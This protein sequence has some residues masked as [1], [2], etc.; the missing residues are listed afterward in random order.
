MACV[1]LYAKMAKWVRKL[2]VINVHS[3]LKKQT[4]SLKKLQIHGKV[5]LAVLEV[6]KK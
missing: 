6:M 1:L 5:I 4:V 3:A 2:A